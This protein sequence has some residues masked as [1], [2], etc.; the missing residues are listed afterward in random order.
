MSQ[1]QHEI[2]EILVGR[3]GLH[4]L[5]CVYPTLISK[6]WNKQAQNTQWQ[7]Q[8][9]PDEGTPTQ[10]VG[11]RTYYLDEMKMKEIGPRGGA[12]P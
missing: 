7:I 3:R 8:D 1:K 10:D 9:I 4:K 2:E 6:L 5:S 12:P 11:A